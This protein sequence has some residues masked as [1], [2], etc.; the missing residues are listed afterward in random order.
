M[1]KIDR[2]LEDAVMAAPTRSDFES[3]FLDLCR[4][5]K[6]PMPSVNAKACGFEVDAIFFD[7]HLAVELDSFDFHGTREAF[8]RDRRRDATL[9]VAGYRVLRITW[10][11]LM[12]EPRALATEIRLLLASGPD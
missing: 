7:E 6:L 2:I 9:Q 4:D 5:A 12:R 1:A 8:E 11:R 3:L 10:R